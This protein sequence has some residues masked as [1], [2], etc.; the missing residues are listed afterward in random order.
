[1]SEDLRAE[2]Q[3]SPDKSQPTETQDDAEA[4]NDFWAM[5]GHFIFRHHVEP[6]V[7][8][9]VLE[10]ETFSIPLRFVDVTRTTHTNTDVL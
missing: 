6:R 4:R 7:H 3:G 8:L 9:Y 1:M 2:L 5:E 10:E